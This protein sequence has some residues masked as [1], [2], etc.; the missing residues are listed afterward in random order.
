MKNSELEKLLIGLLGW[1]DE[2][3]KAVQLLNCYYD[4][5]DWQSTD[6]FKPT[7]CQCG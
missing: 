4:S 2:T 7:V 3:D 5:N 6:V 1:K